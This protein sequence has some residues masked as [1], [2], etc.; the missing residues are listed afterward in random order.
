MWM[1]LKWPLWNIGL[2]N[3][4]KSKYAFADADVVFCNS[5]W[6]KRVSR[7]LDEFDIVSLSE[8]CYYAEQSFSMDDERLDTYKGLLDT[9]GSLATKGVVIGHPGF[10]FG[11]NQR[12][13]NEFKIFDCLASK[14][15]DVVAW[16]KALN[17]V[18]AA[19]FKVGA[20]RGICCHVSHGFLSDRSYE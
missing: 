5:D 7:S 1:F 10:T 19:G 9:T 16:K 11:F 12:F 18:K 20:S 3:A 2:K 4:S 15:G 17:I 13:L 8:K 6:A 14:H